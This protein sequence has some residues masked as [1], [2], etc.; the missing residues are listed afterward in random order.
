MRENA[1]NESVER[2]PSP[3]VTPPLN[4][5]P[6]CSRQ[7]SVGRKK[8]RRDKSKC[9]KDIARLN[10]QLQIVRRQAEKYKKRYQRL[11]SKKAHNT[12]RSK[13]RKM[14]LGCRV[15]ASVKRSLLFHNVTVAAIKEKYAEKQHRSKSMIRKIFLEKLLIKY[16][17]KKHIKKS[18]GIEYRQRNWTAGQKR[19]RGVAV[20]C[21]GNVRDF[22]E[23][24]GNSRITTSTRDT[25]TFKVEKRQRRVLLDSLTNLHTKYWEAQCVFCARTQHYEV[26]NNRLLALTSF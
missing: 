18:M 6:E 12:P 5:H 16:K 4:L 14:L 9:Y 19:H 1:V 10:A 7:A 17:L 2:L 23:Q 13:T 24:D 11:T 20:E 22:L 25:I 26:N 21:V 15:N 3:P 8:V